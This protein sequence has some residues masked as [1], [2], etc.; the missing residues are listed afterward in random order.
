MY[1]AGRP[2]ICGVCP[3]KSRCTVGAHSAWYP[4]T[5]MMRPS[6]GCRNG[7]GGDSP[8]Q[9][10]RGTSV[11]NFEMPHL[12]SSAISST[13]SSR[14]TSG[15]ELGGHRLQLKTRDERSPPIA[16]G[17]RAGSSLNCFRGPS[18]PRNSSPQKP[19][20]MLQ[21]SEHRPCVR[22][23]GPFRNRLEKPPL[24]LRCFHVRA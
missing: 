15:D 11:R 9:I 12:R 23:T 24:P 22:I 20:V 5:G 21:N 13:R 8:A 17:R 6:S 7:A 2:E 16:V 10:D 1:Y 19:K 14:S 3:L 4:A 18:S